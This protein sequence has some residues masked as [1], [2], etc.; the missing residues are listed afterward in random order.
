MGDPFKSV[1]LRCFSLLIGL[2]RCNRISV[3]SSVRPPPPQWWSPMSKPGT[4]SVY[5]SW[6]D[7]L[8]LITKS[9]EST[10]HLHSWA[11][12]SRIQMLHG[13]CCAFDGEWGWFRGRGDLA[14]AVW[15]SFWTSCCVVF[16]LRWPDWI[17]A[18]RF[19]DSRESP[20]SR[21]ASQRSRT[22]PLFCE[23]CFGG[24][25]IANR[26]F[27]AIR[28]N[29]SQVM[30]MGAF[31]RIDSRESIRANRPDSCCESPGHLSFPCIVFVRCPWGDWCASALVEF[32]DFQRQAILEYWCVHFVCRCSTPP[33]CG[34]WGCPRCSLNLL[35]WT[36]GH[37]NHRQIALPM[38][39]RISKSWENS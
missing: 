5:G 3:F 24:L 11:S 14:K 39:P 38:N 10:T 26:G 13:S 21:E 1:L 8:D 28:A 15:W 6:R 20:D 7:W 37:G 31:L 12:P 22:E 33:R 35:G 23:S 34:A 30:K 25:K 27:E 36:W 4:S 16:H 9:T 2:S 29:R 18:N 32:E 19:A 17:R